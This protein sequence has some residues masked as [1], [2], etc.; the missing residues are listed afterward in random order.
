MFSVNNFYDYLRHIYDWPKKPFLIRSFEQHGVCDLSE[1]NEI[2]NPTPVPFRYLGICDL[3]DQEPVYLDRL[4]QISQPIPQ[5]KC[6]NS[7]DSFKHL[8]RQDYLFQTTSG[9]HCPII[10]HSEL[11]SSDIDTFTNNHFAEVHYWYHGLISRDWFRHWKNFT[12]TKNENSKR[13]GLYARD[14]SHERSY[15]LDL[16]NSLRPISQNVYFKIQP[17]LKDQ[18]I[19]SNLD[20]LLDHWPLADVVFG[21]DASAKICWDDHNKFDIQIVAE[22]VFDDTNKIHLTEKIFKPMVMFQ[23]FI[24]FANAGCLGYLQNYGF[25]TFGSLWDESYGYIND[26]NERYAKTIEVI[27][28]INTLPKN[29]YRDLLERTKPIVAHNRNHFFSDKFESVLLDELHNNFDKAYNIQQEKFHTM[30][31]GTYFWYLDLIFKK[32]N[33]HISQ[34]CIDSSREI[35]NYMKDKHPDVTREII[36]KYNHLF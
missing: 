22:T 13:F 1:L 35:V 7:N 20:S 2:I 17:L 28:Y 5:Y 29:E 15:R 27:E 23:P 12:E 34:R 9:V 24:L 30:P 31:G 16:I 19:Q 32:T 4:T 21:S 10:C 8:S 6:F 18:I 14:S 26:V 11:N 33:G 3:Y 36:R 25:E